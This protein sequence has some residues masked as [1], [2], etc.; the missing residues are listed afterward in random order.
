M[1][2]AGI[3]GNWQT[4]VWSKLGYDVLHFMHNCQRMLN[5]DEHSQVARIFS[6]LLSDYLFHIQREKKRV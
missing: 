2:L 3:D 1:F 5:V 4:S 6:A